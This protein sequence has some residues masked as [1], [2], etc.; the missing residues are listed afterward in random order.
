MMTK[1]GHVNR[2]FMDFIREQY[3]KNKNRRPK[4]KKDKKK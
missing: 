1:F 4:M 3:I 2:A